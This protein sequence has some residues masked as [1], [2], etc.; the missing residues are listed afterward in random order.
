MKG[1]FK[2]KPWV[3]ALL[4]L[5]PE[6]IIVIKLFGI[7]TLLEKNIELI[8]SPKI[9]VVEMRCNYEQDNK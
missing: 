4:L 9:V 3:K 6:I 7:C 5:L 8:E 1:K 2:M